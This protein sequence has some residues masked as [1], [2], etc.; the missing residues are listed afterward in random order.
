MKRL[1]IGVLLPLL[2]SQPLSLRAQGERAQRTDRRQRTEQRAEIGRSADEE[3]EKRTSK[4]R[5]ATEA[6]ARIEL[7]AHTHNFGDI[8]RRG[9]DV[10]CVVGFRNVGTAPLV[11]T[12][13][14]TSCSCLKVHFSKRPIAPN[15]EGSLRIV[16]EPQKS[17]AGVF[18]KVIQ[19]YS[20]AEGGRAIITVQGNSIDEPKIK[21]K[22]DK[23][24]IK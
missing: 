5:R 23:V 9:G 13:A 4:R 7:Y 15:E 21:V 18:N 16:Y 8:S 17:E 22:Q 1:L 11:L 2:L 10:V 19:L 3:H 6:G 14:V 12:R 24:K 20:N